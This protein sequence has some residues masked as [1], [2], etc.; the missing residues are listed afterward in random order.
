MSFQ[1]L[2]YKHF[3]IKAPIVSLSGQPAILFDGKQ[4]T[5]LEAL[6][7]K[8]VKVFSECRNGF[9]GACKTQVISGEVSYIKQPIADL[10]ANECLPCCCIPKTDVNLALPTDNLQLVTR[11]VRA[12]GEATKHQNSSTLNTVNLEKA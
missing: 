1:T 12:N 5:L 4:H 3:F 10:E 2:T 11:K 7:F 9:C 8:K 6:E